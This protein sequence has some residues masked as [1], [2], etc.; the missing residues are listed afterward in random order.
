MVLKQIPRVI[1]CDTRRRKLEYNNANNRN[2]LLFRISGGGGG[3]RKFRVMGSWEVGLK[4][5][6]RFGTLPDS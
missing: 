5:K 2:A 4:G 1:Y 6:K 3:V